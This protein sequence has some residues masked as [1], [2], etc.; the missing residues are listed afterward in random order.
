[1][2]RNLF[3]VFVS[4][5]VSISMSMSMSLSVYTPLSVSVYP[6]PKMDMGKE[7]DVDTVKDMDDIFFRTY[8]GSLRYWCYSNIGINLNFDS[9]S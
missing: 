4:M 7:M 6:C 9:M 5:T 8:I 2:F 3:P 1:M